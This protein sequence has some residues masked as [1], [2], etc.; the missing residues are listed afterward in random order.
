MRL[1]MQAAA[2]RL[3]VS[4]QIS[5][6]LEMNGMPCPATSHSFQRKDLLTDHIPAFLRIQG[7]KGYERNG[8]DRIRR[9]KPDTIFSR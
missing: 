7:E 8:K 4:F 5:G 6:D 3:Y 2:L 1:R 9:Q